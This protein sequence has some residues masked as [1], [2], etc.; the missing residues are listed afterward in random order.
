[1][2]WR[3]RVVAVSGWSAT[4]SRRR[5]R[6]ARGGAGAVGDRVAGG[7]GGAGPEGAGH[8]AGDAA[9]GRGPGGSSP[10]T[11]G[12]RA[13]RPR[14]GGAHVRRRSGCGPRQWR[15]GGRLVRSQPHEAAWLPQ[16]SCA[17]AESGD[18]AGDP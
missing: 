4:G 10:T 14:G 12:E 3:V 15:Y 11:A 2:T 17:S 5:V 1:M 6:L 8:V 18:V 16:L 7:P 13:D 9:G